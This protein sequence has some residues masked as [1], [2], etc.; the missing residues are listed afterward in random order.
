MGLEWNLPE[1]PAAFFLTIEQCFSSEISGEGDTHIPSFHPHFGIEVQCQH[2][3]GSFR[4]Y[5][6]FCPTKPRGV[7]QLWFLGGLYSLFSFSFTLNQ[8]TPWTIT[9]ADPSPPMTRT[10]TQPSPTVLCP[11]KELSGIRTVIVSIWW[12]DTGTI[13]TVRWVVCD[14]PH[15]TRLGKQDVGQG[16]TSH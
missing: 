14:S 10:Q 6:W 3:H 2:T 11:T 1:P 8:G 9:M 16:R 7:V 12:A 4:C 15:L 5:L 13:T